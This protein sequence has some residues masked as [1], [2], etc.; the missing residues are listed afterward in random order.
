MRVYNVST[1]SS[2]ISSRGKPAQA[3]IPSRSTSTTMAGWA[4]AATAT[5]SIRRSKG[6]NPPDP[7][8][9]GES[10]FLTS[11]GKT[12][13]T[14]NHTRPNW[15]DL[16]GRIGDGPGGVALLDHP[17][18][19]PLSPARPAPSQQALLLLRPDGPRLLR[20]HAWPALRLALSLRRPRRPSRRQHPRA[21]LAR[22]R[23]AARKCGSSPNPEPPGARP[24]A[25]RRPCPSTLAPDRIEIEAICTGRSRIRAGRVVCC[26]WYRPSPDAS[27][28]HGLRH[29]MRKANSETW[30]G[31]STQRPREC[32]KPSSSSQLVDERSVNLL[33]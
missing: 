28:T 20:D 18:Q 30:A 2:S 25:R 1:S 21:P 14:G 7:A 3:P 32:R 26:R 8:R 10:D 15:V 11:E 6:N 22:L 4:C 17:E 24:D 12:A 13:A 27:G 5:G 23:R 31:M 16:S 29:T 19:L 33:G 9:S